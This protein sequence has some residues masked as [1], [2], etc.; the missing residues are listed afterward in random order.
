MSNLLFR[1]LMTRSWFLHA[2]GLLAFVLLVASAL[3]GCGSDGTSTAEAV[4]VT[5][6]R[7]VKTPDGERAFTGVLVNRGNSRIPIAQVQVALY[8]ASGSQVET[9]QI[10][11]EDIPA[12]DS[13]EFSGT[14]NS[15]RSLSQAQVKS[16]LVP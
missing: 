1:F 6:P 10:E 9:L 7:L 5:Q 11:V 8:D 14:I 4:G 2:G 3:V 16:V 13:V 12:Q 15:D